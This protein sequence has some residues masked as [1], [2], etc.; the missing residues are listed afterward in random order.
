M[1]LIFLG[2]SLNCGITLFAILMEIRQNV[3]T[4]P[5][6]YVFLFDINQWIKAQ[7]PSIINHIKESN[8]YAC[9]VKLPDYASYL[10]FN[11]SNKTLR[12]FG[13][14]FSNNFKILHYPSSIY[15]GNNIAVFYNCCLLYIYALFIIFF[16][17]CECLLDTKIIKFKH[18]GVQQEVLDK[19]I[20]NSWSLFENPSLVF[21]QC[22]QAN[23]RPLFWNETYDYKNYT[24]VRYKKC[25]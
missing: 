9:F 25:Y 17:E 19:L 10:D 24:L 16:P 13:S 18:V 6:S 21:C 3:D 20:L 22:L 12:P 2:V 7:M 8:S 5:K 4:S 14:N 1:F 11:I 15:F 23:L